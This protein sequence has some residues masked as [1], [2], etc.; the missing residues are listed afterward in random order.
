MNKLKTNP[1]NKYS[2]EYTN[3]QFKDAIKSFA[4]LIFGFIALFILICQLT[5][6]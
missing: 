5:Q 3:D 2:N 6:F 4:V 1:A